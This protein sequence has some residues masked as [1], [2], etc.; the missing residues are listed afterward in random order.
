MATQ[1]YETTSEFSDLTTA[2]S[3]SDGT[4][5]ILQVKGGPIS[6]F[7]GPNSPGVDD[8]SFL[9]GVGYPWHFSQGAE[10]IWVSAG[11]GTKIVVNEA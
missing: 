3:L 5:Y 4:S 7:E 6:Y 1:T 2:L 9:I 8:E 10:T 11:G